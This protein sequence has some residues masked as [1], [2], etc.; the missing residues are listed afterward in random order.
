ML[1]LSN[2][3]P[4]LFCMDPYPSI[5][6]QKSKKNLDFYYFVTSLTFYL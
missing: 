4:S 3:N 2:P 5:N 1:G 6:K